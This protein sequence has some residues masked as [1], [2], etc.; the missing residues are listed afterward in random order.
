MLKVKHFSSMFLMFPEES[1]SVQSR[2]SLEMEND[3]FS[4]R[5]CVFG[6]HGAI[7]ICLKIFLLTSFSLPFSELRLLGLAVDVVD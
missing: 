6:L 5:L 1:N 3:Y 4:E 7:Y 2:D